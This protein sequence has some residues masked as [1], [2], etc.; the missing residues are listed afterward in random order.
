[1]LEHKQVGE[2]NLGEA[3]AVCKEEFI[4]GSKVIGKPKFHNNST[5]ALFGFSFHDF[6]I[7]LINRKNPL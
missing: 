6:P 1:M 5:F 2:E 3:C 7:S 4:S